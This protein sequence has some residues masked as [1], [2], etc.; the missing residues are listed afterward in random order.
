MGLGSAD[1]IL[2]T[3][4]RGNWLVG[5]G[6]VLAILVLIVVGLGIFVAVNARGWAATGIEKGMTA[7]IENAPVDE[8][9]KA[10]SLAVVESFVQRFRDKDVSFEQ[11]GSIFAAL[12]DSPLIPAAMAMGTGRSYFQDSGLTEEQ[13]ADGMKQLE[14]V[15]YGLTGNRIDESDLIEVLQPLKANATDNEVITLNFQ[16]GVIRVKVPKNTTDEEVLAFIEAARAKADEKELPA[17]PPAF[18]L[19]DELQRLIDTGLGELSES[20]P[21]AGDD[22]EP[23]GVPGEPEP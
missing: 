16:S 1:N 14:R 15:T 12:E 23:A 2:H 13:Q 10:E 18:D 17:E 4:R 20:D 22:T 8:A 11:L 9:E 6:V 3:T 21:G 5:C 7:A 19:S